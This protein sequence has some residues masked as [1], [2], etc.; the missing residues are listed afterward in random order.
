MITKKKKKK[1]GEFA[2]LE[3][4]RHFPKKFLLFDHETW[5]TGIFRYFQVC[6]KHGPRKPYLRAF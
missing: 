4:F 6:L 5:Y 3:V 2:F 1:K